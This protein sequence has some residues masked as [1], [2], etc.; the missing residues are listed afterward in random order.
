[1]MIAAMARMQKRDD[2]V[3]AIGQLQTERSLVESDRASG[4]NIILLIL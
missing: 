4:V 1:M 2:A 3:G